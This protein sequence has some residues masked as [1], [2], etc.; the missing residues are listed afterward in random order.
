MCMTTECVD[1]MTSEVGI[2]STSVKEANAGRNIREGSPL[3]KGPWIKAEDAILMDY[4]AKYGEGNWSS[5]HRRTGLARCGKSCRLRWANHLKPDL[6]K[7][8]FTQE[9]EE[10]IIEMHAKIGNKWARMAAEFPG[11]TDNDIKN[12]WNTR[13]KRQRR[14]EKHMLPLGVFFQEFSEDKQNKELATSSSANSDPH[15]LPINN[16]EIP[17][18]ENRNFEPSQQLYPPGLLNIGFSS[19]LDT[20]ATS[21]RDQGLN[22]S[23]NT[24]SVRS[25]VHS[26]KRIRG[27][28]AWFSDQ[29][30]DLSQAHHQYQNDG[31]LFTQSLGFSSLYT[32]NLTSNYHPSSADDIPGIHASSSE[33]KLKGKLELPSFQTPMTSWDSPS[34]VPSIESSNTFIQSPPNEY[35]D[36]C[37]LSPQSSDLLHAILYGS[38]TPKASRNN[39]HQE[40][41]RDVGPDSCP[42]LREI[43][44]G[45]NP[46]AI[47]PSGHTIT[48]VFSEY[49][50][51]S[52]GSL[53]DH[54]SIAPLMG[55]NVNQE[56]ANFTPT[57]G[58]DDTSNHDLF[59]ETD[60][61]FSP[62]DW[63][64]DKME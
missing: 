37:S 9:E 15:L 13:L 20:P 60:M 31:S 52:G 2:D 11:R 5:V 40:T 48:S 38:Q 46:D 27:S 39:S 8:A 41:S 21:L 35:T 33:P 12:F 55:C 1:R 26:S 17:T 64:H 58:N 50:P 34:S 62:T 56:M 61:Y 59:S 14:A 3:K 57:A 43:Q 4:V 30:V 6:K 24:H 53:E 36:S 32:R 44:W 25:T 22:S 19:F 42:V 28:E 63:P 54:Q 7:G 51:S 47:T 18:V 10:L 23:W 16:V 29:N 45:T 49:T